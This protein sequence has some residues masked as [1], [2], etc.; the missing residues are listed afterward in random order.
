MV[1]EIML[2][3]TP[4]LGIVEAAQIELPEEV[5]L[6]D[7]GKQD[8]RMVLEPTRHCRR[9]AARRSDDEYEP[10]DIFDMQHCAGPNTGSRLD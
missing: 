7:E 8:L 4:K 6:L 5:R 3:A 9:A 1:E 2:D 10:V